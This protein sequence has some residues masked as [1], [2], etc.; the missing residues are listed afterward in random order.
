MLLGKALLK[1][2]RRKRKNRDLRALPLP[3]PLAPI[4]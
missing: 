4:S 1:V 2:R 3:P